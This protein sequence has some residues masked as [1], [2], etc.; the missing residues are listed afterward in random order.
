MVERKPLGALARMGIVA[1]MHVAIVYVVAN[2][3]GLVPSLITPQPIEAVVLDEPPVPVD[4]APR[5]DYRPDDPVI[6]MTRP[7]ELPLVDD[8]IETVR[9][10]EVPPDGIPDTSISRPP[11]ATLSAVRS[12]PRHPLTQPAYPASMIR[13]NN[14]GVVDVEVFVQPNGRVADARIVKSSGFEAFDRATIDEARRRWRLLPATR[15]GA[16]YAQWHTV[17]VVFKLENR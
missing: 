3:L 14:E 7:E 12:D 1:G 11:R 2:S 16:P 13:A 4:P 5:I 6:L 10:V 8:P 9:A 17:R 15:D